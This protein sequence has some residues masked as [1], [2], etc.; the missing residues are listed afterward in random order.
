MSDIIVNNLKKSFKNGDTTTTVLDVD[1]LHISGSSITA[2]TGKSG[3]GK[4]TFLQILAGLE[5]P[6]S[7]NVSIGGLSISEKKLININQLSNN[8]KSIIRR[9]DLGFIYQ[10]NF[11]LKDFNVIDNLLIANNSKE[12]ALYLLNEV[13]L[14]DKKDRLHSQLSGGEKQRVSICRALM[15]DPIFIFADEPT[16]SLDVEN[17]EKIWN[18]FL[19]LKKTHDFGLIMVTHDLELANYCDINHKMVNGRIV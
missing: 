3:S 5:N 6:T 2:I 13:G 17:T 9:K 10:K 11:L 7:G 15:N 8:E 19:K 16:G 1:N 12:K 18:L 14:I 4:S